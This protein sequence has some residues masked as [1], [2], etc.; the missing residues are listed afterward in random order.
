MKVAIIGAGICGLY[1]GWK[2]SE[3]GHK[4]TIFEK[5]KQ[6]GNKVCSGLFSQRIL[7]FFPQSEKLIENQINSVILRFPKKTAKV[8]FSKKFFLM[9]HW[10]LDKLAASL[11]KKAG[12]KIVLNYK[13]KSI[14]KKFD[15][16]IGCDGANSFVR[17]KLGLPDPNFRLGIQGFVKKKSFLDFVEVW[18]VEKGFIWKIPRGKET[19][20]GI[21]ANP[22]LAP[23]IFKKFLE[24]NDI[25]LRKVKSKIIPQ[26]L[27][28]PK[29]ASV[30]LCGDAAG[31]TKPWSGGG[32]IWGLF[33]AKILI[34]SF[35]DFL[36]YQRRAKR[37]FAPKIFLSKLAVKI[38]YFLG[39]KK[40][41]LLPKK[42]TIESDFLL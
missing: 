31:L 11:A 13:N 36:K 32:V 38:V 24:R 10:K 41:W 25:L 17:E 19:E 33:A 15:R 1:L 12:A 21:M 29:N 30:T 6:I 2:L 40:A 18:P 3:K 27:I 28:I 4:V 14:P 20:Y 34:K 23:R 37:F 42:T 35:P 9:S 39:F 7:K 5:K 8:K 26:G 16:V 22:R